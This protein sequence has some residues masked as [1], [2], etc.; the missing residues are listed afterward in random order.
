MMVYLKIK[1]LGERQ[2]GGWIWILPS[3]IPCFFIK[4]V[5]FINSTSELQSAVTR[6]SAGEPKPLEMF[7]AF[8]KRKCNRKDANMDEH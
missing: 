2:V 8:K 3:K 7:C 5:S 6:S 1:E 4:N